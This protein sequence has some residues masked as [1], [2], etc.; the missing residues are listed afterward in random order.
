M[1]ILRDKQILFNCLHLRKRIKKSMEN[2]Q[3]YLKVF[4]GLISQSVSQSVNQSI[5]IMN[6]WLINQQA[7]NS[8]Q[9]NHCNN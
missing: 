4:K 7:S 8:I 9:S 5:D 2:L 1:K 6:Q 3:T